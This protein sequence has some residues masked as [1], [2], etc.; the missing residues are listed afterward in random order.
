MLKITPPLYSEIVKRIFDIFASELPLFLRKFSLACQY[1]YWC[2]PN[3][4][5]TVFRH[6]QI[7]GV[8][9]RSK[10]ISYFGLFLDILYTPLLENKNTFC[11]FYRILKMFLGN[12]PSEHRIFG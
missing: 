5:D 10:N 9:F 11:S 1:I 12:S 2:V 3:Y 8:R 7:E 4:F 6:F